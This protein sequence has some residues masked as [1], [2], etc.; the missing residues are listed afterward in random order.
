MISAEDPNADVRTLSGYKIRYYTKASNGLF[1]LG[2]ELWPND[3][4]VSRYLYLN[5]LS[6]YNLV[7]PTIELDE[8]LQPFITVSA[9]KPTYNFTGLK[10][11]KFVVVN[12][13][14]GKIDVYNPDE[15]T[16][17]V[18][19]VDRV[20]PDDVVKQYVD[21]WCKYGNAPHYNPSGLNTCKIADDKL[22]VVYTK[23]QYAAYQIFLEA[24]SGSS[25]SSIGSMLCS[26][27]EPGCS[28]Y[29]LQGL[30]VGSTLTNKFEGDSAKGITGSG[31]NYK[32]V[33]IGLH[34]IN[35]VE[36]FVGEYIVPE[37][38]YNGLKI[39]TYQGIVM[40]PAVG[41]IQ[42]TDV[43]Y[44]RLKEDVL[45]KYY[46]FLAR[47]GGSTASPTETKV[48]K[49]VSGRIFQVIET[50]GKAEYRIWL[51]GITDRI[52]VAEA[53]LD[54]GFDL[55]PLSLPGDRVTVQYADTGATISYLGKFENPDALARLQQ[56]PIPFGK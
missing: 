34:R 41:Q 6:E 39:G 2:W 40:A 7:D 45:A 27:V 3:N 37:Q 24:G 48:T 18:P 10:L 26:T 30:A 4:E 50:P 25:G 14:T 32:I 16:Q 47:G 29:D 54:R 8:S 17:K 36:T 49:I 11:E 35:G 46:Q 21:W 53:T 1:I 13:Q 38:D 20:Q 31:A 42:A 22:T 33:N 51:Q 56:T 43:S 9:M 28:L 55:V 23:E 12:A 44:A 52:F 5:G 19:W 15:I